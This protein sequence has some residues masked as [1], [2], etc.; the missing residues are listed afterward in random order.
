MENHGHW[1]W[2]S[3]CTRRRTN[4]CPRMYYEGNFGKDILYD[5][6]ATKG[7]K[8]IIYLRNLLWEVFS[9]GHI[10]CD[11]WVELVGRLMVWL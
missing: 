5:R 3:I 2:A 8:S 10:D 4:S 6:I 7:T 11:D 1:I 9:E